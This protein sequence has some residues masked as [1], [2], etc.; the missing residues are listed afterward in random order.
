MAVDI[1]ECSVE[2]VERATELVRA[3]YDEIAR[4]KGVMVLDPDWTAYRAMQEAGKLAVLGA[5]SGDEL[6]GYSILIITPHLHYRGLLMVHNDVLYVRPDHRGSRAG[7]AL[8]RGSERL[9]AQAKARTG[10]AKCMLSWHAK[11]DT[12]LNEL[13][14]RLGYSVQDII[15]TREVA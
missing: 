2:C 9:A 14:P 4:N 8:I 12:A 3:H 10:F 15:Y 7:L 13:M 6:V 11:P 1:R 5:W